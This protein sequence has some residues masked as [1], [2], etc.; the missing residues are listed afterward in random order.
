MTITAAITLTPSTTT[1]GQVSNAVCTIT[2]NGAGVVTVTLCE[3]TAVAN[4]GAVTQS[5][6]IALG[7]PAISQGQ[8]LSIASGGGTLAL[9]FG[10]A[11]LAPSGPT[12]GFPSS[13]A[14]EVIT[15]GAQCAVSD[16]STATAATAN[17]TVNAPTAT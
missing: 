5:V 16:G 11:G 15:I 1:R 17:L 6:P 8:N 14:S 4:G 3:P 7:R 2:N 9:P 13:Q 12:S 10:I